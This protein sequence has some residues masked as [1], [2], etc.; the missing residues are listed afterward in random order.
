MSGPDRWEDF[1]RRLADRFADALAQF[2]G[3]VRERLATSNA[4][5]LAALDDI[6]PPS[7]PTLS[8]AEIA[9]LAPP[10]AAL[11]IADPLA[12]LLRGFAALD[13][14]T[15]QAEILEA[16]LAAA[17]GFASRAA[18]FLTRADGAQGWGSSGFPGG[19]P[20][21]GRQVGYENG[22]PWSQMAGGDGVVALDAPATA[23]VAAHLEIPAGAEAVLIP[24]V[25]RD[26]IAAALYADR[27]SADPALE[28]SALQL[29]ALEAAQCLE[30]LALRSRRETPTLHRAASVRACRD[31]VSLNE[32]IG[33][34][35]EAY[36]NP[37]QEVRHSHS[38]LV[39]FDESPESTRTVTT[40]VA[41][42]P[43]WQSLGVHHAH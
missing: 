2:R 27:L 34:A 8:P 25:L 38:V 18:V 1:E 11:P 20:I 40:S 6:E 16:L 12:D 22:S 33:R 4:A 17:L 39:T 15:S 36:V 28:V 42:T 30:L 3:S 10:A 14:A 7:H 23:E 43:T 37:V 32:V 9:E 21:S 26:R 13:R 31:G 19:D 24:L 35:L 41:V 29:L 5:L